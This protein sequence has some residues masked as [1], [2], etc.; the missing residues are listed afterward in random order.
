MCCALTLTC[1]SI[2][3]EKGLSFVKNV[4]WMKHIIPC[5]GNWSNCWLEAYTV[6]ERRVHLFS[7]LHSVWDMS[8]LCS[9]NL[10]QGFLVSPAILAIVNTSPQ[11]L[12]TLNS[13]RRWHSF[14]EVTCEYLLLDKI[15][16]HK[17]WF[18]AIV[19]IYVIVSCVHMALW[20]MLLDKTCSVICSLNPFSPP[21]V[22]ECSK[23]TRALSLPM[24][25]T[26][27]KI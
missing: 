19:N 21:H 23:I 27:F 5:V 12:L 14:I 13:L 11:L 7:S 15:G 4:L 8:V 22:I 20:L 6:A 17:S 2:V 25:S 1:N 16:I 24:Q 18:I 9:L 26:S 10:S 3:A